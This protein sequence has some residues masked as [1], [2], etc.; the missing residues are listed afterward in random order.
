MMY[1]FIQPIVIECLLC[2]RHHL[3]SRN[4]MSKGDIICIPSKSKVCNT[5]AQCVLIITTIVV[6]YLSA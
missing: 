6:E 2:A 4:T 1:S 5:N 3:D